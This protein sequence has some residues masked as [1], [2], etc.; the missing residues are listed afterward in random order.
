MTLMFLHKTEIL[1]NIENVLINE[2]I[3]HL[4]TSCTE[5]EFLFY[6]KLG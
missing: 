3:K 2:N 6:G 4:H 1:L 5:S